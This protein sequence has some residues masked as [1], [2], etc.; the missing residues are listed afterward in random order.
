MV[1]LLKALIVRSK[2]RQREGEERIEMG[3]ENDKAERNKG[4]KK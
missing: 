1:I 4:E 2:R 3:Q